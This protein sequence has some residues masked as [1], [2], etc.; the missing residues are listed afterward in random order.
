MNGN[1]QEHDN[2][3]INILSLN[4]LKRPGIGCEHFQYLLQEFIL[5]RLIT[6]F[7]VRRTWSASN[8]WPRR[9]CTAAAQR[10]RVITM[11]ISARRRL[12]LPR[13]TVEWRPRRR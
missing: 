13:V 2:D 10:D 11:T 4:D 5:I 3:A 1:N 6:C 8:G 7:S 9:W 12:L